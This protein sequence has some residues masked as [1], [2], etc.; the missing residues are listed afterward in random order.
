MLTR[1]LGAT[2]IVV[3][4]L[5]FGAGH[6]DTADVDDE[7]ARRLV[8]R[9]LD[10]GVTFFDTARGYGASEERLG[11][12]LRGRRD[13]VVLS[14]KVGY[15]V[16]GERDWTPG[17]VTAGIDRARRLLDT[18]VI[19][20]VFL[21]SCSLPVLRAGE[22]VEALVARR[23]AGAVRLAGYSGEN[24]ELAWAV[25]SGAFDVVQTSV[26]LADQRSLTGSVTEASRRGL[27]VV[28]KR[29]LA[30][31]AWVP[32]ERPSGRYG[33][34]YWERLRRM[35]LEPLVDDWAGTAVRFA[36]FASGVSTAIVGTSQPAHLEAAARAV[37]R[38]PL[39]AGEVRRWR[40][41]FAAHG[42][43]WPGE[44]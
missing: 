3:S 28:A 8:H 25:A 24:E 44:V 11:R 23:D 39:P 42:K 34:T 33:E 21:H 14:T 10:A 7:D 1:T 22:V 43:D 18:E 9:A 6:L 5:G 2:G 12:I 29:P 27:G 30:N 15:D 20:V 26:N 37:A 4:A 32:A 16:P 17:A 38:G 41:A 35:G 36:V 31:A 13:Q 40:E 19:D